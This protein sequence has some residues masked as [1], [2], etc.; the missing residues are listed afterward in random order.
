MST[1]TLE[2]TLRKTLQRLI[3]QKSLRFI[4]ISVLGIG[5]IKVSAKQGFIL[6]VRGR[7]LVGRY[8]VLGSAIFILSFHNHPFSIRIQ[9]KG[10]KSNFS[11]RSWA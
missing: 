11:V 10:Y 8:L 6:P 3:G 7:Y 5:T 2:I 9:R 1:T 4:G